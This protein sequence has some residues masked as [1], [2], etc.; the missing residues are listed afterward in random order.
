LEDTVEVSASLAGLLEEALAKAT[1]DIVAV[2]AIHEKRICFL[3]IASFPKVFYSE[4]PIQP[5]G[6]L[7]LSI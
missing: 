7:Y 1:L 2:T 5:S 3:I 6:A 4:A